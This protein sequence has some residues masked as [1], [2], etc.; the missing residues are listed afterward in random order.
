VNPESN[1]HGEVALAYDGGEVVERLSQQVG[2]L[3]AELAVRDAII[4]RLRA[5]LAAA[6]SVGEDAPGGKVTASA[7]EA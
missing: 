4:T 2:A 7:K 3:T 6:T 1:G 5:E